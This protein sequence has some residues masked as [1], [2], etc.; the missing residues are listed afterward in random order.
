MVQ[1]DLALL[2]IA[3]QNLVD[4]AIRYGREPVLLHLQQ[5]PDAIGITVSDCG[6]GIP[7]HEHEA[8][9]ERYYRA[10]TPQAR[11]GAGI[12]LSLVRKI[13]SLHGGRV[14]VDSQPGEG[15]RFTI[16]LPRHPANTPALSMAAQ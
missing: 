12:G 1:A 8:I 11:S 13:A 2:R 10:V 14:E 9:F 4:N 5:T 7:A 6:P 3:I 15:S 16:W